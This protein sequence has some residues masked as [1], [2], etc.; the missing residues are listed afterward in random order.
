MLV[1]LSCFVAELPNLSKTFIILEEAV[2][3]AKLVTAL[4]KCDS[5]IRLIN[6]P[7]RMCRETGMYADRSITSI[8]LVIMTWNNTWKDQQFFLEHTQNLY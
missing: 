4:H 5:L 8:S 1:V 6:T 2:G 7:L 3:L